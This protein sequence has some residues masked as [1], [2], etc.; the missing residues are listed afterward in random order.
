MPV[1]MTN[2]APSWRY[3]SPMPGGPRSRAV[4]HTSRRPSRHLAKEAFARPGSG[5]VRRRT[6]G[7]CR[8]PGRGRP[9]PPHHTS[10]NATARD[11]SPSG[12]LARIGPR[13][14]RRHPHIASAW[15]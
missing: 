11:F 12:A 1:S 14:E 3:C 6:L 4:V 5:L 7:R 2:C 15:H 8:L 10:A 9:A 13:T